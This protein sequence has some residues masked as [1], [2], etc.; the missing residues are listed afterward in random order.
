LEMM[1]ATGA[2]P[3]VDRVFAFEH[4][5]EAFARLAEGPMGKVV[6]RVRGQ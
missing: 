1:R 5:K 3:L 6:V 2:K 4:L